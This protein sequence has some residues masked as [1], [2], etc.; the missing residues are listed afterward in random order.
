VGLSDGLMQHPMSQAGRS[1][2]QRIFVI[3]VVLYLCAGFTEVRGF[4]IC[5]SSDFGCSAC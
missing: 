3:F 5:F 1:A 4:C 2:A